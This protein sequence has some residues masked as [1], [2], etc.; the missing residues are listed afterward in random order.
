MSLANILN[1]YVDIIENVVR[2]LLRRYVDA[3]ADADED[4]DTDVAA[5]TVILS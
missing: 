3:G 2:A 4:E 5:A 1:F